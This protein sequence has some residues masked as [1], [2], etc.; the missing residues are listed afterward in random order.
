VFATTHWSVVVEAGQNNSAQ[1]FEA[2][3]QLCRTYWY[4]LYAY[5]RRKGYPAPDAQ[6]LTQEFFRAPAGQKLCDG[7]GPAE[8]QVSLFF[9]RDIRAL[10]GQGVAPGPRRETRRGR[11]AFSLDEID[12]E[13]RYLL[14][15][16][17]DLTP[18][19]IFDRR[20]AT[21]LLAQAMAR[22]GEE[23]RASQKKS[24]S[25]K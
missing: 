4:P 17:H 16:A 25:R 21:T 14:E 2:M 24:C 12:A 1:A 13:N 6:D 23:C 10:S 18:A 3:T 8:R 7:G 11:A 19:K 9:A 15:P 20:W 22:L 5:V